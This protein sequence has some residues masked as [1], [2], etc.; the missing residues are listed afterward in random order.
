MK[1]TVQFHGSLMNKK[2]QDT[3]LHEDEKAIIMRQDSLAFGFLGLIL[4][5][6]VSSSDLATNPSH[7]ATCMS[8]VV[9]RSD[10]RPDEHAGP[11]WL[12][13]SA[14]ELPRVGTK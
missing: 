12:K 3:S 8:G 5:C 13:E 6:R 1:A 10:G 11:L 2:S 9:P 14:G 7:S 4:V